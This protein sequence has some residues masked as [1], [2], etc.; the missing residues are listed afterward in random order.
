M[1]CREDI[2]AEPSPPLLGPGKGLYSEPR[3]HS[4]SC[5]PTFILFSR[6]GSWGRETGRVYSAWLEQAGAGGTEE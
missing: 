2:K 4:P 1:G 3:V 6:G 5:M